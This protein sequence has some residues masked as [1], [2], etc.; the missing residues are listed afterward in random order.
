MTKVTGLTSYQ[1][2]LRALPQRV[3]GVVERAL[4]SVEPDIVGYMATHAPWQDRTGAARRNLH[5][6]TVATAARVT[7]FVG[8]G[9]PYGI[10]LELGHQ[11]RFAILWPAIRQFKAL[12]LQ[13]VR[14]ACQ[15]AFGGQW[16]ATA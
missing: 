14:E 15:A 16:V 1:G 2:R 13:A 10:H 11:G 7:L 12:I 3:Q 8:H 4:R 6:W 5:A 9:V